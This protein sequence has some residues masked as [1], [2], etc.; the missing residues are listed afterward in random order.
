MNKRWD[1][2]KLTK[3]IYYRSVGDRF[4][5]A[6]SS[7]FHCLVRVV[8]VLNDI[9]PAVIKWPE[10]FEIN[11]LRLRYP[12]RNM[13]GAFG[14]LDGTYI[15]IP[16]PKHDPQSNICRKRF[17]AVT[18]QG[19]C[20]P[21]LKF[22]DVFAGFPSSAHDSR[23]LR[24]SN[25]FQEIHD[26]PRKYFPTDEFIIA[27][28]AYPLRSWL[29]TPFIDRG[30]LTPEQMEFNRAVASFRHSIERTFALLKGK[31]RRLK[32]LHML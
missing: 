7:L 8:H 24:N 26:N 3:Y 11:D 29:M 13:E 10:P 22:I 21:S 18:L 15:Q 2:E 6:K 32:Y 4:D 28:K 12:H 20:D 14:Y 19:I 1:K 17:H 27:D 25:I 31:F 5:L 9:A 30:N 16:A 23:V